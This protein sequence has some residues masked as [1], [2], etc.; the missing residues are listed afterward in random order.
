[1]GSAEKPHGFH[2]G[3][4]WRT[5]HPDADWFPSRDSDEP[6]PTSDPPPRLPRGVRDNLE[7]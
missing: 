1:M 4:R 7:D 3:K 2:V 6:T 5:G